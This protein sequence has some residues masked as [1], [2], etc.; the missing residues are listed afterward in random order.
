MMV[1]SKPPTSNTLTQ[2]ET[3]E[4]KY[5]GC[6]FRDPLTISCDF[7]LGLINAIKKVFPL[8]HIIGCYFH[9]IQAI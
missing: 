2:N 7:E 1:L 6:E 5:P 8:S 9:A 4:L 3:I